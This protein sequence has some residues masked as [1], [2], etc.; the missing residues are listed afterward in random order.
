MP[1]TSAP[2][3]TQRLLTFAMK[4]KRKTRMTHKERE[5]KQTVKCLRQR[6]AWCNR[7]GQSYN[8][9]NEQ[10]S[11]YPRAL[12]DVTGNPQRGTK[13]NWTDKLGKRYSH[14]NPPVISNTLPSGWVPE[15]VIIDGMFLLQCAPLR[16]TSTISRYAELLFNRFIL[17]HFKTGAIEVHLL[18]DS[19]SIQAFNPKSHER[20]RRDST[21]TSSSSHVHITFTPS[22]LIP[23][24]WRSLIECRECK[25]S[26]MAAVSLAYVQ[27]LTLKLGAHQKFIISGSLPDTWEIS[28]GGA[29]SQTRELYTT[30]A[31]KADMRIWRHAYQSVNAVTVNR[32]WLSSA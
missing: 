28:G 25:Q 19:P 22:T 14:A 29:S 17:T 26:I 20:T 7:T 31:E 13:S 21:R 2:I 1:S 16:Q 4:Q 5:S 10:Y 18:F 23:N 3:R 6:L 12:C 27:T 11:I 9:T 30:N 24:N 32:Q 15:A 8:V